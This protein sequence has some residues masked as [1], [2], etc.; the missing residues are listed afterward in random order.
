MGHYQRIKDLR[1]D[2]D[3]TQAQAAKVFF[4]QVNQ[5]G[6]YERGER[7]LPLSIAVTMADF[8]DV[9]LDYLAGRSIMKPAAKPISLTGTEVELI[10]RFRLL[11]DFEK[12][13]VYEKISSLAENK[14]S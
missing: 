11:S 4:M 7:E 14:K 13:Q 9:S 10:R 12:G 6:R 8:Y 3:M 5:Y 2:R 1:E